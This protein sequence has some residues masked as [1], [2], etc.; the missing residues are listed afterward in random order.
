MHKFRKCNI[1][2][3]RKF[4]GKSLSDVC[5]LFYAGDQVSECRKLVSFSSNIIRSQLHL[6]ESERAPQSLPI[7]PHHTITVR[8]R[9]VFAAVVETIRV[10]AITLVV[11]PATLACSC[12]R[13]ANQRVVVLVSSAEPLSK[14]I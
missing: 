13:V 3:V 2:I 4:S 7:L 10:G 9:V 6:G 14:M 8:R 12:A 11:P 1:D 5:A